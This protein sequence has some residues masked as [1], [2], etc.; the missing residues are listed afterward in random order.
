MKMW[1]HFKTI[2]SNSLHKLQAALLGK[3]TRL[4]LINDFYTIIDF[5]QKTIDFIQCKGYNTNTEGMKV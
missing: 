3:K 1:A 4:L 2:Y 5:C